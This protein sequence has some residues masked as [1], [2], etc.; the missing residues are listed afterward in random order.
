MAYPLG[1]TGDT[2]YTGPGIP[3]VTRVSNPRQPA[4][5][6]YLASNHFQLEI[7]RLPTVTYFCQTASIPSLTLTPTEQPTALGLRAKWVGGQYMFEDLTV[8]FIVDENMKNWIE[9][10]EWM[11]SIGNMEGYNE[12]IDDRQSV[13]FFSD[14]LLIIT[15][16]TYKPKYYVQF[17]NAFPTALSAIEFNSTAMET[18]PIIAN[19]TFSYTS[20]KITAV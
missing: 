17:K 13:D 8:S 15:N 16:S 18:E 5:N 3:D 10:F 11:E 4:T 14:I 6:N 2:G 9:V 12:V 19:A 20:Y 1:Y 7:T